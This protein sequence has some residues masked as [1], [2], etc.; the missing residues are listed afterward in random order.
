MAL[1][2]GDPSYPRAGTGVLPPAPDPRDLCTS[3]TKRVNSSMSPSTYAIQAFEC[4]VAI[5]N[6]FP[7]RNLLVNQ[8]LEL[9]ICM[10]SL[11]ISSALTVGLAS[12]S[13][14]LQAG[15]SG[16][17]AFLHPGSGLDS[18]DQL[19]DQ[20]WV[21]PPSLPTVPAPGPGGTGA[22]AALSSLS[23]HRSLSQDGFPLQ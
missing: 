5:F 19:V 7:L 3:F 9:K 21:Q 16:Q 13:A 8:V 14:G 2:P 17:H 10:N 22:V 1:M 23:S 18:G 11:A 6:P 15:H 4:T 20:S 12:G